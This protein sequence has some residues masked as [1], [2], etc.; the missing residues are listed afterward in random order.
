MNDPERPSKR[1]AADSGGATG[2]YPPAPPG[3]PGNPGSA[4]LRGEG[5]RSWAELRRIGIFGGSFDPVHVGHLYVASTAQAARALE[6]VVFVP[7]R[8]P[9]HKPEQV[10]ASGSDRIA[11]LEIAL[12]GHPDWTIDA[13]ELERAGPSYTI[14]TLRELRGRYGLHPDARLYLLLGSDN[15]R[16]FAHWKDV[17]LLLELALPVVVAREK[18]LEPLIASL[19]RELPQTQAARLERALIACEPLEISSTEIRESL[20]RGRVPSESLPAGVAEYIVSRGIYGTRTRLPA[21]PG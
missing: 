19:G 1:P 16:G 15:L 11:M 2:S 21:P 8:V 7:A 6:R 4:D 14:D 13:L 17:G 3:N 9:P 12:R 5:A 18:E 20:A 10:L